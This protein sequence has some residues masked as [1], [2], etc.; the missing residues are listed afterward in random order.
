MS[1]R[2][3]RL[4]IVIA[5]T[6]SLL[7][8][9]AG[10]GGGKL[11]PLGAA[12]PPS[13]PP[14]QLT[15]DHISPSR[16]QVGIPQNQITLW[17]ENFS[18]NSV[19]LFDGVPGAN[20]I[21]RSSNEIDLI[22]DEDI[23]TAQAGV[24]SIQVQDPLR[25]TSAQFTYTVYEPALGPQEFQ[26]IPSTFVGGTDA[27]GAVLADFDGDGRVDLVFESS[28]KFYILHGQADGTLSSPTVLPLAWTGFVYG[29]VAA[30]LNG[31]GH[32]DLVVAAV[33][34]VASSITTL[35]NDGTGNLQPSSSVTFPTL[36]SSQLVAGDFR[37][38]GNIDLVIGSTS[39]NG[40][41]LLFPGQGDG[42]FGT[43]IPL[44]LPNLTCLQ[45][46][47]A[48]FNGDG[49]P[50]ILYQ[51]SSQSQAEEVRLLLNLGN[52]AFQ[53]IQPASLANLTGP[54]VVGDFNNDDKPDMVFL[55]EISP[56][57]PV[58]I[59]LGQ[60]DGTFLAGNTIAKSIAGAP[61]IVAIGDFDGDGNTD[62]AT[63]IVTNGPDE[64]VIFWGD[65]TGNFSLPQFVVEETGVMLVGDVNG[66]GVPD[67]VQPAQVEYAG[68]TLGSRDR[69]FP[70]LDV[71]LPQTPEPGQ[72]SA[73]DV[74]GDGSRALMISGSITKADGALDG[75]IYHIQP[76]G[77]FAKIGN[78][79]PE[80]AVLA[81]FDGDGIADLIGIE[82]VTVRVWK[83][84]GSGDFSSSTPVFQFT[85][86]GSSKFMTIK[87]VDGD[88]IPD[89]VVNGMI[90]YGKGNMTFEPVTLPARNDS[91]AVGDFDGDGNIDIA[92]PSGIMYGMGNRQFSAPKG[93]VFSFAQGLWTVADVN[94]DGKDDIIFGDG[95]LLGIAL[96]A[97][98][99]IF[100]DQLLNIDDQMDFV[101][102]ADVNG[103]GHTDIV[104]G[105][106]VAQDTVLFTN[107]GKG[108]FFRSSFSVGAQS[109]GGLLADLNGDGKLDFVVQNFTIPENV[110][111][112]F[113][114]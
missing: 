54:F 70:V 78:T 62:I 109:N 52:G 71:I 66:D 59:M 8:I 18:V 88:K 12:P 33:D 64:A 7:M 6:I 38:T 111:I 114:K 39:A 15:L 23:P 93:T 17:G 47:T 81:D 30:D 57:T 53:D 34:G 87:D 61:G 26:A 96:G 19:A 94:G 3:C 21:F 35:L 60:G 68:V 31:D 110:V 10:C 95:S 11:T 103:D 58:T 44:G 75:A 67:L 69:T 73:G 55:N 5:L 77:S 74:F 45:I 2:Y 43:P 1:S 20:N 56:L 13:S 80:A 85:L 14:P 98:D 16:V 83:G 48:D 86:P 113:H 84:D 89:I 27:E 92:T 76:N 49:L 99:G 41:L 72:L 107:D 4:G 105:T 106:V 112:A 100:L 9:C 36:S 28:Q 32:P 29:S 101:G 90:L 65:G 79:P 50:D 97:R 63:N 104:V 24:H 22:L 82:G 40:E 37:G 46:A 102:A 108:G 51:A 91:F 25:G 42:S